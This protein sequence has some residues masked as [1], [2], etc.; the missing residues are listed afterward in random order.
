MKRKSTMAIGVVVFCFMMMASGAAW[1]LPGVPN[2]TVTDGGL[3]WL[4]NANCFGTKNW[5]EAMS[6]AA[7]LRSGSCG[8]TDGSTAGQWRLPTKDE[9]LARQRNLQG[10]TNVL[11]YYWSSSN[12]SIGLNGTSSAWYVSMVNGNSINGDKT[13]SYY[14]W[15]VRAGQ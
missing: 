4:Q 15:A 9:L 7:S 6:A 13:R 10:F 11:S 3:V 12:N 8:L 2:G 5:Q 1:S 14:V